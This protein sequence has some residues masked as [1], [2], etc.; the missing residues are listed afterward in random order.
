MFRRAIDRMLPS[1]SGGALAEE[2]IGKKRKEGRG[3]LRDN[4]VRRIMAA[5]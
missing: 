4:K 5:G 3:F 1:P 2:D